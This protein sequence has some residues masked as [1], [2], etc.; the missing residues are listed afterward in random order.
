MAMRLSIVCVALVSAFGNSI[1]G[2]RQAPQGDFACRV[3]VPNGVIA[4]SAS[5]RQASSHGTDKLSVA[6]WANG[7]VTFQPGGPGFVTRDGGLG[8]KFGWMRGVPGRLNVKGHRLDGEASPLRLHANG[9]YGDIGFQASYLIFATP[10]CW[11]VN[12]QV[13]EREDSRITFI[14][15]IVKIGDGPRWRMD[16][17]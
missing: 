10:G 17:S 15:K 13:G 11:E 1:V 2:A 4:G 14:T 9:G 5:E 12:A 3:T 8:M 7:T 16:P 6:L